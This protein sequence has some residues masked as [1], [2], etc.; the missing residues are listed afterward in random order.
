M[1]LA[2]AA[3]LGGCATPQQRAAVEASDFGPPPPPSWRANVRQYLEPVLR[4]VQGARFRMGCPIKAYV[5]YGLL[6]ARPGIAFVGYAA[7]VQINATN[8]FGGYTGFKPWV[9]LISRDGTV[10]DVR[11][12]F[13]SDGWAGPR[14]TLVGNPYEPCVEPV[15][16]K[17]E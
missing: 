10:S 5:T 12:A 14:M 17:L 15:P 9:A 4:D 2:A 6:E 7:K 1:I 8:G 3:M 16:V 13:G 11:E